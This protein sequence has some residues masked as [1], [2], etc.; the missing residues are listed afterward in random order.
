M[1]AVTNRETRA[2]TLAACIF[3]V[4]MVIVA[5][6]NLKT[7]Q[8]DAVNAFLNSLLEE[9]EWIQMPL[10]IA[11]QGKVWHLFKALYGFCISSYLW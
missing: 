7:D 4:I 11:I 1:Q 9:E 5:A 3:Q 8:L 6:F 10:G 2:N